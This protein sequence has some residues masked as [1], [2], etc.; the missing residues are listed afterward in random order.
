[1]HPKKITLAALLTLL[2]T[3]STAL[4]LKFPILLGALP[5]FAQTPDARKTEAERLIKEGD[6]HTL[7]G[8]HVLAA[9]AFEK[10]LTIY[11]EIKDSQGEKIAID[12]LVVAY[13]ALRAYGK[14]MQFYGQSSFVDTDQ[15]EITGDKEALALMYQG[16]GYLSQEDYPRA[17]AYFEQ[18]L[19]KFRDVRDREPEAVALLGI[20]VSYFSLSDYPK[21][22]QYLEQSLAIR[23]ELKDYDS[24]ASDLL[25]LGEAYFQQGDNRQAIA[26]FEQSLAKARETSDKN[27]AFIALGKVYLNQGDYGKAITY[28]QQ[29]L[30]KVQKN[31]NSSSNEENLYIESQALGLLGASLLK[32][33]QLSEAEK[34]LMQ[35]LKAFESNRQKDSATENQLQKVKS[36]EA[37]A[38]I[39]QSLQQVLIA[40]NKTEAALE[41]SERGR[42]RV[43]TELVAKRL[44]PP[45]SL[46]SLGEQICK[47]YAQFAQSSFQELIQDAQKL[48]PQQAQEVLKQIEVGQQQLAQKCQENLQATQ[49]SLQQSLQQSQPLQQEQL[50]QLLAFSNQ[51]NKLPTINPPTIQQVRQVAKE[52]KATLVEYSI[53]YDKSYGKIQ[54]K[55]LKLVIWAV[56]PT[57]EV[58]LK[59]VD[60]QKVLNN[61]SLKDL[62]TSSREAIGVR[63]RSIIEVRPTQAALQETE[64]QAIRR[65]QKLHQLLIQ[66]I[67]QFLPTDPNERVIFIPQNELF[68]VPFP[69]LQDASGKYLVEKHTILTAPAIQVLQLTREKRRSVSG[70]DVLV[71]GNPTMPSITPQM[72]GTPQQ[73][74]SLPGAEKEALAIANLLNTKPL[75]GNLATKQAIEQQMPK[76]RIIHL[77]THGLLDDFKGLGVPGAIALAPE[78]NDDGLL[79]SSEIFDLKLNAELVVLSACDTGRGTITGDGVI[80]LSRSLITAGVPSLIVSLWSVPDAPT[81]SLMT[82][83]YQ[84][85]KQSPDKAQ[86]LRS[87][88]LT[89][90]KQHPDPKDWAAF[91]LI[92]EAN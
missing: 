91:T 4:P 86:A 85:L 11:R 6:Q 55:E 27:E 58:A 81:A 1:M 7:A 31:N 60:L 82:E 71:V 12:R 40:Q 19:T 37:G 18:N 78:G 90:M 45:Q 88:M 14:V 54:G 49:Q 42:A 72:G 84:N 38:A 10:A 22:I 39:F 77:A 5:T 75:T 47:E 20:G 52:Q 23:R 33:G 68:L 30:A 51:S 17:I 50:Q 13:M 8:E 26:Y 59:E 76:A 66:P 41:V 44:S 24:E 36:F 29:V 64:A 74:P 79:T 56:K 32:S 65:L 9:N 63:G 80:G 2:A 70:S 34:A 46:Q 43:F 69:A 61:K 62:V 3:V 35:A 16:F 83:F 67:A 25:L 92:G 57:G 73:L 53:I 87:A 21:A 48:P 28:S 15:S 89:T